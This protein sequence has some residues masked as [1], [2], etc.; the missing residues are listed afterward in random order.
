MSDPQRLS[1]NAVAIAEMMVAGFNSYVA[2]RFEVTL[3]NR[4]L[5]WSPQ[6]NV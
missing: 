5:N 2:N 6:N 3:T 1:C 4:L